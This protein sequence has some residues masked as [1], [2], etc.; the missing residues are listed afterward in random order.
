[1]PDKVKIAFIEPCTDAPYDKLIV[2]C[3]SETW[4]EVLQA[5]EQELDAQFSYLDDNAQKWSDMSL[6]ISFSE[7][8]KE[9][10]D[11]HTENQSPQFSTNKGD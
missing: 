8:T 1:M 10:L 3:K 6:K 5:I 7:V 2:E 4:S 9:W 11:K